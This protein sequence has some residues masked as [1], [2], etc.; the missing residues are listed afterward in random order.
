MKE[1]KVFL[2]PKVIGVFA[3]GLFVVALVHILDYRTTEELIRAFRGAENMQEVLLKLKDTESLLKDVQRS[4]RGYVISGEEDF[5]AP[6]HRAEK[7]LPRLLEIL[8]PHFDNH[9]GQ[10]ADLTMLKKLTARKIA[11]VRSSIALMKQ[12]RR[13][14]AMNEVGM[15]K[16]KFDHLNLVLNRLQRKEEAHLQENRKEAEYSAAKNRTVVLVAATASIL[17]LLLALRR[18]TADVNRMQ[19]LQTQLEE[20]NYE[21]GSFN[22]ELLATNHTLNENEIRL[23]EAQQQLKLRE[24]KLQE[25]NLNMGKSH[26]DLEK[27]N[28]ELSTFSYSIS[29]DLRAPLRAISGYSTILIEEFASSLGEEEKRLIDIIR[30]NANRMGTLIH[31]L[32]EFAKFGKKAIHKRSFDMH[33]LVLQVLADKSLKKEA[34]V[35]VEPMEAAWGDAVLLRQVWEN[36]IS[37]AIKFSGRQETPRIRISYNRNGAKQVFC[38]NDN[39]IGFDPAYSQELFQVFKRL[40]TDAAF[41]GTGAGLAIARRIVEAHA[42][43]IWASAQPGEGATF[44]FSLPLEEE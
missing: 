22:E 7:E 20:A 23:M 18:I 12:G 5:L 37:N 40:H 42:G 31:D 41:E 4:H 15:G 27:A 28:A 36:L 26:Q 16:E 30:I 19:L 21:L 1:T 11:Y 6:F 17:L 3:F 34:E 13:E 35:E 32:L 9:P 10:Q 8:E 44:C 25:A 24:Q 43:E 2:V 39:G 33:Y 29:H 38:I 14:E